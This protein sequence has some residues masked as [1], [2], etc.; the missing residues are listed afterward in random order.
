MWLYGFL[1]RLDGCCKFRASRRNQVHTS[2][3]RK[4]MFVSDVRDLRFSWSQIEIFFAPLTLPRHCSQ[5]ISTMKVLAGIVTL[6]ASASAF[7]ISV[8]GERAVQNLNLTPACAQICILNPKWARE[9]APEC[10]TIDLGVEY[11]TRLCQNYMYQH[12]LDNCFKDKCKVKDRKK[13]RLL[14]SSRLSCIGEGTRERHLR[15][16]WNRLGIASLVKADRLVPNFPVDGIS[17]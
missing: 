3:A 6:V 11:G 2:L 1:E 4:K 9:Y 15:E 14:S 7:D 16:L 12:M 17:P 10:S 8:F 13:V 5:Q